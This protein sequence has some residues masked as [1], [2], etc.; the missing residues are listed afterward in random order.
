MIASLTK[1]ADFLS[2]HGFLFKK[3]M[4]DRFAELIAYERNYKGIVLILR[5]YSLSLSN[6]IRWQLGVERERAS[7]IPF[8]EKK[9]GHFYKMHI[10]IKQVG[11]GVCF[12]VAP[13]HPENYML[14]TSLCMYVCG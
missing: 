7:T 9:L 11:F 3:K 2:P 13:L 1:H 12:R 14:Q 4:L 10:S 8:R 5:V 6:C